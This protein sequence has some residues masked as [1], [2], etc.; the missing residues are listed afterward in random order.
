MG[1]HCSPAISRNEPVV[2]G[3]FGGG[4]SRRRLRRTFFR[5]HPFRACLRVFSTAPLLEQVAVGPPTDAGRRL[6][7]NLGPRRARACRLGGIGLAIGPTAERGARRSLPIGNSGNTN[8]HQDRNHEQLPFQ[9][10]LSAMRP[11][12]RPLAHEHLRLLGA[13]CAL[14]VWSPK[15]RRVTLPGVGTGR[16]RCSAQTLRSKG[17]T[18]CRA[19]YSTGADNR[20]PPGRLSTWRPSRGFQPGLRRQETA[21]GFVCAW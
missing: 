11:L 5:V 6:T 21:S 13:R 18:W 7:G 15:G 12:I 2:R 9:F 3:G 20:S 14:T 8:T 4:R 10:R 16:R 17:G 1:N 19:G